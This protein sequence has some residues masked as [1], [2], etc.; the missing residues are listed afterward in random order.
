MSRLP[1]TRIEDATP[2]AREFMHRRGELN[3]FRLLAGAPRVFDGWATWVD[4]QLDST[5]FSP[6]LREMVI[7]RVAHLQRCP[8]E[9]AQHTG[10]ADHVGIDPVQ[11][12]ALAPEGSLDDGGGGRTRSSRPGPPRG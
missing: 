2:A 8:Y 4:R 6:R 12:A 9:L 10:S 7:L 3:V 11:R 5:T 1:L